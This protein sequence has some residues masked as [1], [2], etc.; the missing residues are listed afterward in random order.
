LATAEPFGTDDGFECAERR[1]VGEDASRPDHEDAGE[2]DGSRRAADRR[3]QWDH[4]R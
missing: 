1:A 4:R 2:D 3:P